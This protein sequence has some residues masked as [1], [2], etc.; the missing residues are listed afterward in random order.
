MNAS[1]CYP[2]FNT[3]FPYFLHGA[4]YNPDQW[5]PEVWEED[6]K[7]M[8]KARV[9]A[10]S[11][12]IFGWA[13]LEPEE[14][15]FEFDWLDSVL[16]LL[17]R[18][19]I[20]PVLATPTAAHPRW[21]SA[22]YPEIQR[23]NREQV[24][25]PHTGRVNF[26]LTS[27][28]YREKAAIITRKLA[29]RYQDHTIIAWHVHNEYGGGCFC[30][31]CIG[32]FRRWL[33][34]KYETLDALNDAWWTGFWSQTFTD[35]DQV[36]PFGPACQG[37][38]LDWRRF[39]T[40]QCIACYLNEA[41]IL[42]EI[43]P[44]VPVTTNSY[45]IFADFDPR[46]W[47]PH[48]DVMALDSYPIYH[49]R[50]EDLDHA[51]NASFQADLFRSLKGGKPYMLLET[52]PSSTNWMP[53]SKLKRPGMHRL[54]ALQQI[55][56]GADTFMYFQWRAGRGGAEKFHGAV[57]THNGDENT[58]VFRDVADVGEML[59]NLN[60]VIG[61]GVP[62]EVAVIYDK[63]N[64][65][66][67]ECAQGP[68]AKGKDYAPTCLN[69]Y[70]EFWKRGIPVDVIHMDA[71]FSKYK[72]LVAPMLYMLRPGVAERIEAFVRNGGTFVA[73]YLT[74]ITDENDKCF[75]G[76]FPGPLRELLGIWAEELDVLYDDETVAVQPTEN[77]LLDLEKAY[78]AQIFCDLIHAESAD[79]L[80]AYDGE[81]YAGRPALT[82]NHVGSGKAFYIASRN[83][84]AFLEDFYGK[85][86]E[87]L[88]IRRALAAE[89]PEG[90]TVQ[91]RTDGEKEFLFVLNF[92]LEKATIPLGNRQFTDMHKG[93]SVSGDLVLP[94]HDGV[95]LM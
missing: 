93:A 23:V 27:P 45:M 32:A 84:A 79:V 3:K 69:H 20:H 14:G 44:D 36:H 8:K 72:L 16:E 35:W 85:L 40:D 7:L 2:P 6:V 17:A 81:F 71:E 89:L 11:I 12:P 43:T 63:E 70:Q 22:K 76:G 9:N 57:V 83:K 52:T 75:Y 50:K 91:M 62:A 26:C 42:H 65:W 19:N 47:A 48:L 29:E 94:P 82:V 77:N 25:S 74:G 24:R 73:T 58:R 80:A 34:C 37:I 15:R 59:D 10:V 28:I 92:G 18:N 67:I 4:D 60:P 64:D 90:V 66:A 49:N 13:A 53:V 30:E 51:V 38:D 46:R 5:S 87:D 21:M 55:G 86:I 78:E 88:G 95:A 31:Q 33:Q 56:H 1:D 68:R 54:T 61:A 39:V 41:D